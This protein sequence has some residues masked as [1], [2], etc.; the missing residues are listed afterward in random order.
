M[1]NGKFVT[2]YRVST[3]QQGQSGVGLD[4]QREAVMRYLSNGAWPPLAEFTEVE[5][6]KGTN[7]LDRRP[8]LQAALAFAREHKATRSSPSWTGWR[9]TSRSFPS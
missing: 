6:G 1:A 3:A 4:T 2:Y 5:T 8:Q 7:A 9:V